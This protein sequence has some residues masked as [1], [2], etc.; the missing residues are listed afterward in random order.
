MLNVLWVG[1]HG[2]VRLLGGAAVSRV[3]TLAD[4]RHAL[5]EG[6]AAMVLVAGGVEGM[7]P[8][9][10]LRF[11]R[12]HAPDVPV[13]ALEAPEASSLERLPVAFFR[14]STEGRILYS[15]TAL[16]R[17]LGCS[18]DAL[19]AVSVWDFLADPKEKARWLRAL[20]E[21]EGQAVHRFGLRKKDGREIFVEARARALR[22]REGR[23]FAY[24]GVLLELSELLRQEEWFRALVE[25]ASDLIYVVGPD[26]TMRYASPNVGQV[27]GYDPEGYKQERVNI[28]AYIHPEDLP[29]ARQALEDLVRHPGKTRIYRI[30]ILDRQG[31]V[32]RVRVWGRNLLDHPAVA[33]IVLNVRDVTEEAELGEALERERVRLKGVVEALPGVVYQAEVAEG[34]DVVSAPMSFVSPQVEAILG[35]A[36]ER[37]LSDPGFFFAQVHPDDVEAVK[38]AIRRARAREGEVQSVLYRYRHGASGNWL[39]LRDYIVFKSEGAQGL[40]TGVTVDV[41][42]TVRTERTVRVLERALEAA[43]NAIAITDRNGVIE[44]V[45][46]ALSE[47]TGYSREE[48][49]GRD[50]RLLKSGVQDARFYREMW[51]TILSGRVWRGTLVNRRK[52]GRLYTEEMTITPTLEGGEVRHFVVIKQDV[53]ERIQR[54]RALRESEIRFRTLAE[55]APALILMWQVG[56]DGTARLVYAN[57]M[58]TRITG[59]SREELAARSIWAF[60]HPEDREMVRRRGLARMQGKAVSERYTFRIL[61]KAGEV[62]WLD[63]SGAGLE[64]GGKPAALGVG[65]DVTETRERQLDLEAIVQL[66]GVMRRYEGS[67]EMMAAALDKVMDLLGARAGALL[68]YRPGT[69]RLEAM[70][71]RGWIDDLPPVSETDTGVSSWVLRHKAPRFM[72]EIREDPLV[73]P[74]VRS[75]VPEGWSGLSLPLVA[76]R[77]AMGV[78]HLA[79]PREKTPTPRVQSRAQ[80]LSEVI[81]NALR[82]ATLREQ[83]ERRIAQLQALR[84]IDLAISASLDLDLA[85]QVFLDRLF[86]LPIDAAAIF[87]YRAEERSL[88]VVAAKGFPE[89]VSELRRLQ[90]PL[91]VGHVGRAALEKRAIQVDDL[92][93]DPGFAGERTLRWGFT[94]ERALPLWAKGE[95]LGALAMFTRG[96][97]LKFTAEEEEF[98]DVLATQ[99]TIAIE[100]GRLFQ[101]L[102]RAKLE[103]EVAYD[104]TLEGWGKAVELRDQ[105]T[106]GHTKRVTELTLKLARRLGVPEEDLVHIRRGA[107]LHDIGK[108]GIPDRILLKPGPLSEEEWAIMKKHPVY[109]YEWLSG[110]P[111]LRRALD[112]PYAHHERWDGSGYPRGL[113]GEAI[114][115]AARIF[116]VADVYDALTSDRPYRKAWPRHKAIE[117][118]RMQAGKQFDPRVV[119]AF[120]QVIEAENGG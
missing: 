66:S 70:A 29:Y 118:I 49:L 110:I 43:A 11:V 18:Q 4:L 86:D 83:L 28:E 95:L 68:V 77:E 59:Y 96:R 24:E 38:A 40:L 21:A 67:A 71:A 7:D 111:F 13:L 20:E 19:E 88:E 75:L 44:W 79:W 113:K 15:N 5:E 90:V 102:R 73:R 22:D 87:L 2:G 34:H 48:L 107:M 115:R 56:E 93:S 81:A 32:R 119:E 8:E 89:P 37:F 30:R 117:Y 31:R 17:L 61:T 52:D 46:P 54:E 85:L 82:R 51:D 41:T 27:L 103:L 14:V 94:A 55:T 23:V 116:A 99:G 45:N 39:W 3:H 100:N 62:R 1:E 106:A 72:P 57:D 12:E 112:I 9:S 50:F 80:L 69:Y 92:A 74:E 105:E 10:V 108:L 47:L 6:R 33:G 16:A 58:A 98:L 65:L 78:L 42:A 25:N 63:Y 35:H 120:L 60:V 36:P 104:L 109:A 91:G 101:D 84:A 114:P 76:G 64:L 97:A 26:G 53:T